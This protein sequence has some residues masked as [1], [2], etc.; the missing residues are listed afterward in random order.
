MG[1]APILDIIMYRML[2]FFVAGLNHKDKIIS[3]FY[4]NVLLSNTSYMTT[5]ISK[6]CEHFD[7]NYSDILSLKKCKIKQSMNNIKEE[8]DWKCDILEELLYM[9]DN[10]LIANLNKMEIQIMLDQIACYRETDN[11]PN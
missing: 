7:I 11:D 8:K 9:R 3:Y 5:N 4:K 2:S 6:I 10:S 1:T